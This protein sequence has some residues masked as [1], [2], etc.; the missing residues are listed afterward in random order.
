M[1]GAC[2][3]HAEKCPAPDRPLRRV[4]LGPTGCREPAAHTFHRAGRSDHAHLRARRGPARPRS[5]RQFSRESGWLLALK[6]S[7]RWLHIRS[8]TRLLSAWYEQSEIL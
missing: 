8:W 2:A 4:A 1:Y 7:P 6:A 3:A 5:A